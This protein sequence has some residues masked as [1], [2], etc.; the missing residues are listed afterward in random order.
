MLTLLQKSWLRDAYGQDALDQAELLPAS[1][2]VKLYDELFSYG[3]HM[4]A[5]KETLAVVKDSL[6]A[7]GWFDWT[8]ERASPLRG[9]SAQVFVAYKSSQGQMKRYWGDEAAAIVE[10]IGLDVFDL[11]Y[12][13]KS[14]L[15]SQTVESAVYDLRTDL[16]NIMVL[17]AYT[18]GDSDNLPEHLQGLGNLSKALTDAISQSNLQ[19]L[20]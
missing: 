14:G 11:V 6:T 8:K 7:A 9:V 13:G 18:G 15:V 4:G 16:A 20:P 10:A 5:V 17:I 12:E 19:K 3:P 2:V 1:V